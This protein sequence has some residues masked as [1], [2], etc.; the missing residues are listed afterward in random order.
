MKPINFQGLSSPDLKLVDEMRFN[1][2]EKETEL[3]KSILNSIHPFPG[4]LIPPQLPQKAKGEIKI[5]EAIEAFSQIVHKLSLTRL[6]VAEKDDWELTTKQVNRA[7]W[8]YAEHLEGCS[9]ELFQQLGQIGFEKWNSSLLKAVQEIHESLYLKLEELEGKMPRLEAILRQYRSVCLGNTSMISKIFTFWTQL[10]SRTLAPFIRKSRKYLEINF[11][12]FSLRYG[13]Y[14]KL[15]E[16]VKDGMRKFSGYQVFR[17]MEESAREDFK[18]I[19]R[20]LKVWELN[21]RPKSLPPR[22]TVRALREASSL[23]R[24][25]QL[26]NEYA[27]LLRN[28]LYERSRKFK[29]ASKEL[30][31]DSSNQ[32]I[33]SDIIKSYRAETHTLGVTI[34]KYREFCLRSHPD[35]Y[36]RSRWGFAE[37]IVGPEPEQTKELLEILYDVEELD[38]HYEHLLNSLNKGPAV[39]DNASLAKLVRETDRTIHEMA[40]PLTSR[41]VMRNKS[42]KL[43]LQ[44]QQMDELGSFNPAVVETVG[45]VLSRALRADWQHHVLFD[46]PLFHQL[47]AIHQG[48][49]GA[50]EERSHQ[51]R[52]RKFKIL[53]AQI[54]G[55]V[56][57]R[58]SYRHVH[59]IEADMMDVK[60][61][62]QDF[63][64]HL[65]RIESERSLTK[66]FRDQILKDVSRQLLEYRYLFGKFFYALY[67]YEPEG[68][69]IRNQFLFVD[70]YFES[71][72]TQIADLK[73]NS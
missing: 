31:L 39:Y 12:F 26:F 9:V 10:L 19:Y 17:L 21:L 52:M 66:E 18:T 63:S 68:R 51:I 71:Q 65:Q 58:D 15:S 14:I 38:K 27:R 24:T 6:P 45:S 42:D 37:W 29:S 60:G 20:L 49:L 41:F 22:E 7:L 33:L 54:E 30:Y 5:S 35:P 72:E 13:E 62:L 53:I 25:T 3:S 48:I 70:Q 64:A 61:Y 43:L 11:K 57:A 23:E 44:L 40:R 32:K 59:E 55:W 73:R 2:Q 69:L 16:R 47:F 67:Q 36:I 1:L 34:D 8:D 46:I 28:A 50:M 4:Q 56:R